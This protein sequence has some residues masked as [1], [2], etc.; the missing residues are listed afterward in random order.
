MS[1]S[2]ARLLERLGQLLVSM[3]LG[4]CIAA[5]GQAAQPEAARSA[6]TGGAQPASLTRVAA[7]YLNVLEW[8]SIGPSRG[9]RVIA[10]AGDPMRKQVFYF[11]GVG[12]GMWKTEDAGITWRNISDGHFTTSS[13][14]AIDVS[15]SDPRVLY[16]GTGEACL[17]NNSHHGDG[18][19]KSTDGGETWNNVGLAP[20]RHIARI[21][22]HP[23]DPNIVYVAALGDGF[24]PNPDR[25]IF[26]SRD[27]GKTWQRV[28]FRS[29]DVGAVD[30][31][32]DPANPQVLYAAL[33]E[34]RRYQWGNRQAGPGSGLFKTTDGGETW[35]EISANPGLPSGPK[36]RIGVAVSPARPNRVWALVDAGTG[37]KGLY[38]SDDA[39]ATWK[40]VSDAAGLT[41][42]PWYYM[43]VYGDPTNA[44]TVYVLNLAMWKSTD[45]GA[46][47]AELET[48]HGDNHDLWIDPADPTRMVQGNDGG[49]NVSI[50][51]GQTWSTVMNQPTAQFYHVVADTQFP[52]RVYGAQQDNSSISVP[53][54]SEAGDIAASDWE[55]AAA[56]ESGYIAVDRRDPQVSYGGDHNFVYRYDLRTR[57]R[58]DISP[59]PARQ[60]G[61]GGREMKYR[62][63]W[64][65]PVIQSIHD[66]AVIYATSQFI[67]RTSNDG[68]SWDTISPDL[69]RHDPTKLE[70]PFGYGREDTG[71]YW[72]PL[73]R[74]NSGAE[75]YATIFA[76][77]ES[78][79]DRNMLWVGSDDG[80]VQLSRDAGKTYANVTPKDLPEFALISIIEPSPYE[81]G[82][83]YVAA[84]RYKLQDRRPYLFK[85]T[86]Y[87]ATWTPITNGLSEGDFTR[88]IR[89][90]PVRRGLLYAGTEKGV[91]VSFND[92]VF[93]QPLQLNLPVVPIHDLAIKRDDLHHDLVA[94]THGRS[95]WILDN[96]SLLHQFDDGMLSAA[97]HVLQPPATVDLRA[98]GGLASR[99]AEALLRRQPAAGRGHS[100]RAQGSPSGPVTLTVSDAAKNPIRQF[101]S[102]SAEGRLNVVGTAQ[103]ANR[104]VW[105]MRYPGATLVP[106]PALGNNVRP[107]APPGTY[108]VTL[109][110]GGREYAQ[111]FEIKKDPRTPFTDADFVDQHKFVT[112]V[113]DK[114]T[115][116]HAAL[117]RLR[118]IRQEAEAI[119]AKAAD[120]PQAESVRR[121]LRAL[122]DKLYPIEERLTQFRARIAADMNDYPPG[123]DT[124][125]ATLANQASS[126][127]P[128]SKQ[129]RE[130][131]AELSAEVA[132]RVAALDEVIKNEWASFPR[133]VMT[134]D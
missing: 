51:A 29:E 109:A 36:G 15:L 23:R 66:P 75:I 96:V 32:I 44:D 53:S 120:A 73:T 94:A 33:A 41:Q 20:T 114:V 107:L 43:H 133:Q 35:T 37:N 7:S 12:A 102:G 71:E 11:G 67:H 81:A 47:F 97:A 30:L 116:A 99:E 103:G 76:L 105:D 9:G 111:S 6:P 115:E 91:Y 70:G 52:Y 55:T 125:L 63:N 92:G 124:E 122:N 132:K 4:G 19:Y 58:R 123:L 38:R 54:R 98:S 87:G 129:A 95:F 112:S 59:W 84:T 56:G 39:G 18:V 48:P 126:D 57:M 89:A 21:R 118:D 27:G 16:V 82:S 61:W 100:L 80:Y 72:G 108:H 26:R 13:V 106:G 117:K 85:T 119:V 77:A 28:L 25:G 110:V 83:A 78:A 14:G 31:A 65:F 24:G 88:V 101:H 34:M 1:P 134:N 86:D 40:R 62:F 17:R 90:D 69:T 128:P 131:F 8:R 46:T 10:V 3:V 42:R 64:T 74:D 2:Q 121:A 22:I 45:G 79:L 113:R 104:F 130:L 5:C 93:W 127:A 60:R 49:A 50:N 68:Q